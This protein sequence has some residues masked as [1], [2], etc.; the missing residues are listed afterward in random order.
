MPQSLALGFISESDIDRALNRSL[1][2]AFRLGRFD[3]DASVPYRKLGPEMIGA[4]AHRAVAKR[5]AVS[6]LVLLRNSPPI[7]T[8]ATSTRGG[9]AQVV[10]APVLPL[11]LASSGVRGIAVVGPNA[12]ASSACDPYSG[13][14]CFCDRCET[15]LT[16]SILDGLTEAVASHNALLDEARQRVLVNFSVGCTDGLNGSATD[17]FDAVEAL[18]RSADISHVVPPPSSLAYHYPQHA[19]RSATK[20]TDFHHIPYVISGACCDPGWS[21][22]LWVGVGDCGRTVGLTRRRRQRSCPVT[23]S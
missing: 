13:D 17:G 8:T 5:A 10:S 4:A 23:V 12:V 21:G 16:V 19:R 9:G 1:S 15:N 2:L 11:D 3:S 20:R 7:T 14:Y 6:S 18:V 22:I